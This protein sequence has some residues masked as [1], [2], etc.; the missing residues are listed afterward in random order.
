MNDPVTNVEIE[1][2]LSSIRRLVSENARAERTPEAAERQAEGVNER[3]KELREERLDE[4]RSET[5]QAD[6]RAA[7]PDV[8]AKE[9][10]MLVLTPA[11]RV[12]EEPGVEADAS[13]EESDGKDDAADELHTL[14]DDPAE[15]T[16]SENAIEDVVHEAMERDDEAADDMSRLSFIHSDAAARS[17]EMSTLEDRI[18]GLEAAVAQREDD[19]EPDGSSDDDNA[20]APVESLNWEDSDTVVSR[21]EDDDDVE[22]AELISEHDAEP[23]MDLSEFADFADTDAET[24]GQAEAPV[25][26]MAAPESVEPEDAPQSGAAAEVETAPEPADPELSLGLELD[27]DLFGGD[28]SVIDEEAL[29]DM[30]AE[31]VRQELQ[32]SLGERITR[33]VRKLVRREIHRALAARELD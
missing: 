33:N 17:P 1:D 23:A 11:L 29:R 20:G 9:A 28:D 8:E 30:V 10:M 5:A 19:W 16:A 24:A 14:V 27:P 18:A 7:T 22:D 32:G 2:V 6:A 25:P 3:R 31:I 26:E 15:A 21:W 13:P 12:E 4:H